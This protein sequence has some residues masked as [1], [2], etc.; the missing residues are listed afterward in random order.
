MSGHICHI[1]CAG[2]G[3]ALGLHLEAGDLLIA[4]DGGYAYC[5]AAGLEPDLYIGDLDS[6]PVELADTM[7]CARIELPRDKD[8]TDTMAACKEGL[9]RGF[10]QFCLHAALGGDVGHELAN[11]QLLG[12]LRARG[13]R[14]VLYGAGQEVHLID[15]HLSPCSF[16]ARPG[17]RVSV[18]ASGGLAS[19]VCLRGLHWELDDAVLQ[20]DLPLGV[21]NRV[22]N[23]AF[24]L[25]VSQGALLVIIG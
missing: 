16:T 24:S 9:S 10:R 20:P 12:F 5:K 2:P 15:A 14:G 23:G 8:D 25:S 22:E 11:M 13:A 21:S 4:A 1:V 3:Y 18:I 7:S 6:I 17:T 19:G